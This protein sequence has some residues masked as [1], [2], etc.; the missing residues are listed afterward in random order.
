TFFTSGNSTARGLALQPDGKI[1]VVGTR[2]GALT[3]DFAL[4]RYNANGTLD[5]TF[6]AIGRAATNFG[7]SNSDA[8]G[9]AR[10]ADGK[11]P[12]A[13]TLGLS[14]AHVAFGQAVTL[15]AVVGPADGLGGTPTG[16]VTFK[17]GA[18]VLGTALLAAGRASL[19]RV[20]PPGTHTALT[21]VYAGDAIF[22]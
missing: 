2:A 3:W 13:A 9:V 5:T 14:A 22:Q 12:A 20:L 10:Q 15:T 11:L 7:R 6:N 16:T 21:A 1:V 19:V 17:D 18:T 8:V 4:V